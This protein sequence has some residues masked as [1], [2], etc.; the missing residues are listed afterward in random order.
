L[1]SG[2]VPIKMRV[3]EV[4]L[5][6]GIPL[7]AFHFFLVGV[8]VACDNCISGKNQHVPLLNIPFGYLTISPF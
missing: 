1:E 4:H 3:S 6:V 8:V 7:V 2:G 5:L